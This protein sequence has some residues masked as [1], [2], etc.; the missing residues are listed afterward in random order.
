MKYPR[1][2]QCTTEIALMEGPEAHD[3]KWIFFYQNLVDEMPWTSDGDY[4]TIENNSNNFDYVPFHI[5]DKYFFQHLVQE[6]LN[7]KIY[8]ISHDDDKKSRGFVNFTI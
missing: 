1:D 2:H 4:A 3:N 8:L 7:L 5:N 6:S